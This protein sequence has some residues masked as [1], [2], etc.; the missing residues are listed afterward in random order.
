MSQSIH[1]QV[2]SLWPTGGELALLDFG[3]TPQVFVERYFE[4]NFLLIRGALRDLSFS[5]GDVNEALRHLDPAPP[6]LQVFQRGEVAPD[7]YIDA[8]FEHG[9]PRR[10]INKARFYELLR[11][12]ATA[13]M[14][15]FEEA[16]LFAQRLC[17][18]VC[19][20]AAQPT[21]GNAYLSFGGVGTFGRHWDT[22][23][24]FVVQLLGAKR[25]KVFAPTWPLPLSSQ[26]SSGHEAQCGPQPVL[27]CELQPGDVLYLPR[28]WWHQAMPLDEGSFHLSV[29]TYAPTAMDFLLWACQRHT[30]LLP[31]ARIGLTSA[32]QAID[33]NALL[34]ELGK[35]LRDP[36]ELA[37]FHRSRAER[38]SYGELDLQSVMTKP[39][40]VELPNTAQICLSSP[41]SPQ[42]DGM[43]LIVNGAALRLE[44][45]RR[46]LVMQLSKSVSLSF[47]DLCACIPSA[48]RSAVQAALFDLAQHDV[49]IIHR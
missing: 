32:Q 10:R 24:V 2:R 14:N 45:L 17:H 41:H 28:G 27:E 26:T 29:G 7:A 43:Q 34:H 38:F 22:H 30:S 4:K 39:D 16:S 40:A 37:A 6:F 9:A 35:T 3:M 42:F 15:R 47:F 48:P 18:S 36:D 25:W 11:G 49:V 1:P 33:V 8:T 21:I 31:A 20:F 12:G 5:W 13:V 44:P 19:R 23:D 46:A